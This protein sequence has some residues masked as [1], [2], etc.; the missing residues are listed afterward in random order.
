[1]CQQSVVRGSSGSGAEQFPIVQNVSAA[2]PSRVR[3]DSNVSAAPR[4]A[5]RKARS[6]VPPVGEPGASKGAKLRWW[7]KVRQ[8]FV[9]LGIN[10]KRSASVPK[11]FSNFAR[12]RLR[13]PPAGY[14]PTMPRLCPGYATALPRL[15]PGCAPAESRLRRGYDYYYDYTVTVEEL[16]DVTCFD[17]I[18]GCSCST[19]SQIKVIT[20]QI[21]RQKCI[22]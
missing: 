22:L 10:Q 4:R 18:C 19:G 12:S 20:D 1:M 16:R 14:A 3:P 7:R 2:N 5:G 17:T 9:I 13:L 6:R 11:D 15:C 21:N 8:R